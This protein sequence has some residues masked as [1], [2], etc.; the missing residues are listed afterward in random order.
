MPVLRLL[1]T[2]PQ[3]SQMDAETFKPSTQSAISYLAKQHLR[4]LSEIRRDLLNLGLRKWRRQRLQQAAN[5]LSEEYRT[6]PELSVFTAL[7]GENWDA[8]R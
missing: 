6:N 7:D 2:K 3:M 1:E 4:S 5:L 8:A